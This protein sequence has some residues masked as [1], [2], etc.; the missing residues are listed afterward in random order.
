MEFDNALKIISDYYNTSEN[1]LKT[2]LMDNFRSNDTIIP[3]HKKNI[4]LPYCGKIYTDKC[5]GIVFNHGLYT[6]CTE[7]CDNKIDI[8]KKCD[9]LKYGR[10]EDRENFKLGEFISKA[11]KKELSYNIFMQKMNYTANEVKSELD[12]NNLEYNVIESI[13]KGRGRPRKIDKVEVDSLVSDSSIE[14]IKVIISGKDYLKTRE[15]VLLD[16][17]TYEIVG[18]YNKIDEEITIKK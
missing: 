11:G 14:V 15:N 6:Q 2:L 18:M 10:I 12:A 17:N 4:I 3:T 7:D 1:T 8:C 16:V 13:R 9:K 5:K